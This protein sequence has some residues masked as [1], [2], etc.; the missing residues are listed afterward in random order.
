MEIELG[1]TGI[2]EESSNDISKSKIKECL[3]LSSI[4]SMQQVIPFRL[5]DLT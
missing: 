1:L 3:V 4:Y 5:H 2:Y